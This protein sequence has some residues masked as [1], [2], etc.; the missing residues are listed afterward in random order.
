MR[1][2][3]WNAGLF[4]VCLGGWALVDYLF[5]ASGENA[6]DLDS[7]NVWLLCLPVAVFAVNMV[8]IHGH[9]MW[10]RALVCLGIT[11]I[12]AIL[13]VVAVFTFGIRFH[14]MIGGGG[15]SM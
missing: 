1:L 10:G 8:V 7:Y 2:V 3:A 12:H 14:L 15:V 5:V 9:T 13:W 4:V 6:E 11:G